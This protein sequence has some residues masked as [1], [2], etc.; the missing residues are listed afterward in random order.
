LFAQ[1]NFPAARTE[2]E[3][4]LRLEPGEAGAWNNL[5]ATLEALGQPTAVVY[6]AYARSANCTPPSRN[7]FLSVAVLQLRA[8]Q[9]ADAALTLDNFEKVFS[10]PDADALALRALLEQKLGHPP[11]AFALEQKSRALDAA[12]FDR[13]SQRVNAT[14][15]TP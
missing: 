13:V 11:L 15:T 1:K 3:T 14:T 8:A 10:A 6:D 9:F 7:G 2:Y 5:G 12:A 4:T